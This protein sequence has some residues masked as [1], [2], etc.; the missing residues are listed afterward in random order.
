MASD[1]ALMDY[2]ALL[3]ISQ[4]ATSAEIKTA[5][6]RALLLAHPDKRLPGRSLNTGPDIA[7]IQEA[8]RTLSSESLRNAYDTNLGNLRKST[9]PRPAQVISLEDFDEQTEL[10][11]YPCRCGGTYKINEEQ[12][13][14]GQHLLGCSS[15]SEVV[16]VGYEPAGEDD[17]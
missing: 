8:Y 4:K 5:Y 12:M 10:W 7:A 14:K 13:E 17:G 6:H 15:C 16:W 11:S 9:G 2:Y 1:K 3:G